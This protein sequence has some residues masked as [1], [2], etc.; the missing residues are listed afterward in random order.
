MRNIALLLSL[1]TIY[2]LSIAQT[3]SLTLNRIIEDGKEYYLYEVQESEG[4]MAIGR[5]F[6]V[7][8]KEIVDINIQATQDGLSVGQIIKIPVV[9]GRNA[10]QK[11]IKSDKYTY[12]IVEA[13]ETVFFISRKY[14]IGVHDIIKNNPK[15]GGILEIGMELK[16]PKVAETSHVNI[17]IEHEDKKDED[18]YKY[19]TVQPKETPYGISRKYWIS[20]Q[21]LADANPGVDVLNLQI[22]TTLRIPSQKRTAY[23][24]HSEELTD[25][26]YIYHRIKNG[27]SLESISILYN[28]PSEVITKTNNLDEQLPPVGYML[29]IPHSYQYAVEVEKE[30]QEIHIIKKKENLEEIAET[31]Q[32]PAERIQDANPQVKKWNK[33]KKGK[34]LTIPTL[35]VANIDSI[36]NRYPINQETEDMVNYYKNRHQAVG[37]TINVALL[38]PLYLEHNSTVNNVMKIDPV[39]KDTTYSTRSPK[40]IEPIRPMYREFFYG[41]LLAL[42]DLKHE[43]LTINVKYYDTKKSLTDILRVLEDASLLESDIIIGPASYRQAKP[44]SDFCAANQIRLV[45]PFLSDF[46]DLENNPYLYQIFPSPGVEYAFMAQEVAKRHSNSNIIL[47]KGQQNDEREIQFAELLRSELYNPDSLLERNVSYKEINYSKD[48]MGGLSA[49]LRKG[50]ENLIIIPAEKEKLYTQVIPVM[51][52]YSKRHPDVDIKLLGFSD[53]QR[54]EMKELENIFNVGCEIY[55][56]FYGDIDSEDEKMMKFVDDY[57]NY[58]NTLPV[59]NYPYFSMLSYDI[60]SFFMKGL[61]EY[62]SEFEQNL[63]KVDND[64]LCIEFDFERVNNW[65][66]FVNTNF[67]ILDYTNEFDIELISE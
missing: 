40:I 19:H 44:V 2:N 46:K 39:T 22:G 33:L 51:E 16:I 50:Q 8:Y 21:E 5:K 18:N 20:Q 60:V 55:T 26:K 53:W 36:I 1:L 28:I 49:L 45:L 6:G 67:Y 41:A 10:N 24:K 23:K 62:G 61:H 59:W 9:E 57:Q 30:N 63:E 14:G 13:G 52:H 4:F 17:V 32:V 65:G 47:V 37:D 3:D 7:A 25:T 66:G 54:F 58:F 64:G 48:R 34:K 31:Y 35:T 38:W 11:E 29:K 27:E 56:P 15:A 42:N 12:H 43:G